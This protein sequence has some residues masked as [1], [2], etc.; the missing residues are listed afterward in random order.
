MNC[1]NCGAPISFDGRC[2][3]CE[4]YYPE[5]DRQYKKQT[6]DKKSWNKFALLNCGEIAI[7]PTISNF[8]KNKEMPFILFSEIRDVCR[9]CI[10]KNCLEIRELDYLT[11]MS[12]RYRDIGGN[13]HYINKLLE[14]ALSLPA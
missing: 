4:S 7:T 10:D 1:K 14:E 5:V 3:Y 8:V 9:N 12:N 11:K 6:S 13:N 2:K